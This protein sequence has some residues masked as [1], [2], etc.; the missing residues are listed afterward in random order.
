MLR[1]PIS[2]LWGAGEEEAA[3]RVTFPVAAVRRIMCLDTEVKRVA[4]DAVVC[5]ALATKAF[6]EELAQQAYLEA[7]RNKRSTIRFNDVVQ[8]AQQDARMAD[9]GLKEVFQHESMFASA[10]GELGAASRKSKAAAAPQACMPIS[11]FFKASDSSD[12]IPLE[13]V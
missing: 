3:P 2:S 1:A 10:R 13:P 8:V 6:L 9:M 11:K 4:H 12:R 5:T 7:S